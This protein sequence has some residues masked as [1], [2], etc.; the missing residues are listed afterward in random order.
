MFTYTIIRQG[1]VR[2]VILLI[3]FIENSYKGKIQKKVFSFKGGKKLCFHKAR[4]IFI[5]PQKLDAKKEPQ[6]TIRATLNNQFSKKNKEMGIKV[7]V[8]C[9]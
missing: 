4:E 5:F 2:I 3:I 8:V 1:K 6:K 9:L 7:K